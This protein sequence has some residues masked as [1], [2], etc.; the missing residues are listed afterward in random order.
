MSCAEAHA[1]LDKMAELDPPT[2][3]LSGG[4]P[5]A[6]PAFFELLD[7]ASALSLR[8]SLSTNG[9][10]I[11]DSTARFLKE[12]G[13]SYAGVSL[14]GPQAVHD[15]FRGIRGAFEKTLSGIHSLKNAGVRIGL[16]FTMAR[17]LLSAMPDMMRLAEE[18]EVDRICFYHFIPSGRSRFE[19]ELFPTRDEM[20]AALCRL[21]DWVEKGGKTPAEVLTVGNFSDGILCFLQ[22]LQRGDRRAETALNLLERNK[23]ARSGQGIVSVRWDGALFAD[24][25]SWHLDPLGRWPDIGKSP[26][27]Q[28]LE[29]RFGGRCGECRWLALCR[30]NMRARAAA[31]AGDLLDEDPGCVLLDEEISKEKISTGK[32]LNGKALNGDLQ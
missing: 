23:G 9:T 31:S 27:S 26:E 16:R 25:F 28:A 21:F 14:D 17:P 3:L 5:L 29:T 13:V 20:R 30:G 12:K 1:F 11:D 32:K 10:S 2:L 8:V 15:A 7:Y 24:Q 18:L 6:H 4:E 22:L 19:T